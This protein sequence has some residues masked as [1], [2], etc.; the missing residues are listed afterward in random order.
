MFFVALLIGRSGLIT[1]LEG[2]FRSPFV[3][4]RTSTKAMRM[5]VYKMGRDVEFWGVLATDLKSLTPVSF[6]IGQ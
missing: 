5:R 4:T 2:M 1:V 3:F 6:L